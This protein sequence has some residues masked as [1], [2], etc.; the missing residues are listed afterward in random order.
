MKRRIAILAVLALT[1]PCS[2][3]VFTVDDDSPAD[4]QSIQAA[5]DASWH[6]DTVVVKQGTYTEPISFGGRQITVR[7]DNP[8]D[9]VTV[10]NTIIAAG[11]DAGVVFDFGETEESVLAGFTITHVQV[12]HEDVSSAQVL[13]I[14]ILLDATP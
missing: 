6:G 5:I 14:C 9:P 2:A 10:Q 11:S 12:S 4:F 3:T 13:R 7:S 1:I 8:D